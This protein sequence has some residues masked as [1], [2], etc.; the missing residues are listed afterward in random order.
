MH[1]HIFFFVI[2]VLFPELILSP[3]PI[4]TR[5]TTWLDA[6]SY[7]ADHLNCIKSVLR[8]QIPPSL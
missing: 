6:V 3:R 8:T 1:R 7:Y 5:W 4:L 2:G